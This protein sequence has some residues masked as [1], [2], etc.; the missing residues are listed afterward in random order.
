MIQLQFLNKILNDRDQSLIIDNSLTVDYFS[1]YR[2]EFLFIKQH[3]DEYNQVPDFASFLAKFPKFEVVNVNETTDYLLKELAADKDERKLAEVINLIVDKANAG[4]RDEAKQIFKASQDLFNDNVG[5]KPIDITKDTSRYDAY[6][7]RLTNFDKY[8][9]TTGFKELDNIIGGWDREEELAA[10]VARPNKG[11]SYI[12]LEMAAAAVE[13]G[14]NVGLWSGEM[15]ERKVGY[16]FDTLTGHIAN[17]ALIHGN[18]CIQ[19]EYQRWIASLPNRFTGSLKVLTPKMLGGFATVSDLRAFIQREHLDILFV[20]QYSL[21]EDEK[22]GRSD[23][24][25]AA[26]LAN[27]MKK[28]QTIVKIPIIAVSQQ[29]REKID[30][31]GEI[32]LS[33][34]ALSD[35]IGQNSTVVIFIEK[36]DKEMK[37]HLVK[38]RDSETNKTLKYIVDLNYGEFRFCPDELDESNAEAIQELEDRY[39]IDSEVIS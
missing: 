7:D 6:I 28:L 20:D 34:I 29:N 11:K 26:N 2:D 15:S 21:L 38:S 25:K 23:I 9:I 22:H 8:Y 18:E 5:I 35:R 13:R 10:I 30:E 17:G 39:A 33:N 31:G 36:E 19:N 32:T 24:E 14:L 37:L 4:K 3:I 27:D 16:R 12:A 1:E